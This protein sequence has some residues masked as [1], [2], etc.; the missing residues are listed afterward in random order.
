[1]SELPAIIAESLMRL[2]P[3]IISWYEGLSA[4]EK[5]TVR[6]AFDETSERW[7]RHKDMLRKRLE[8]RFPEEE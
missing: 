6:E 2:V 1:M 4:E 8:A 3:S 7:E 5:K